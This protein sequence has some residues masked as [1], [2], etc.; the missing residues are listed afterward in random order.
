MCSLLAHASQNSDLESSTCRFFP[1]GKDWT[2]RSHNN[3]NRR[4]SVDTTETFAHTPRPDPRD[5]DELTEAPREVR[6]GFPTVLRQHWQPI[7]SR[8]WGI[9]WYQNE[10]PWP[11]FKGRSTSYQPLR[12]ICNWISLKPLEIEA[13]SQRTTNRKWPMGNRMF[14]RPITSH[15]PENQTRDPQY[16]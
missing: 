16:A 7:G 14:K 10:W 1:S 11:M 9:D 4:R 15:D 12:H 13:W 6:C 2:S 3:E 8:I 5:S